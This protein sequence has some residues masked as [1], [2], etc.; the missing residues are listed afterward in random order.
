M[1]EKKNA[2]PR[3]YAIWAGAKP[4]GPMA[5]LSGFLS[6]NSRRLLFFD[7]DTAERKIKDLQNL[8]LTRHPAV[9]YRSTEYPGDYDPERSIQV[10]LIKTIELR[11]DIDSLQYEVMSRSYGNTGGGCMVGTISVWLPDL[12]KPV[13]INCNEESVTVTSADYIWDDDHS[14][15]WERY[16]DVLMLEISLWDERPEAA[17]ALLPAIQEAIAYTIERQTASQSFQIPAKWLPELYRRNIDPEYLKFMDAIGHAVEIGVGGVL[18][19]DPVCEFQS[20]AAEPAS[21][22]VVYIASPLSGDVEQN[23]QFARQA[24]RYAMAQGAVPFAPHLLYTQMLDDGKPEERQLGI[25]MGSRMLG[26][27]DELW[28]CGDRI[29]PGMA[30]EKELAEELGIPVRSIASEE[31]LS[32]ELSPTKGMGMSM[33]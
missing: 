17:G 10:E 16:E 19:Y 13:W 26:R 23:L 22:K 9:E 7:R 6:E 25:E 4:D 8:R 20:K 31:I 5:G 15:S 2:Q 33:G 21:D 12:E 27:C 24:C 3:S 18:V 1:T 29:S 14:G 11:P 28:L 32:T 30:G